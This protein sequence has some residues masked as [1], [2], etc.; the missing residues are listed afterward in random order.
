MGGE[1]KSGAELIYLLQEID[2]LPAVEGIQVPGGL[3]RDDDLR[4]VDHGPGDRHPLFL[5]AGKLVG[6]VAHLIRKSHHI[7]HLG[8][9]FRYLPLGP[10]GHFERESHVLIGGLVG[11]EPEILENYA[12]MPPQARQFVVPELVHLVLAEEYPPAAGPFFA[13]QELDQCGFARAGA[14]H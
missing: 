8:H 5:A 4:P 9:Q 12:D 10:A 3:V 11:Q 1:D 7:E 14:S 6:K 13:D 2:D